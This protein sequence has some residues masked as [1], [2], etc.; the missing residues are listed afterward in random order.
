MDF[1]FFEEMSIIDLQN[2]YI[3]R[4]NAVK[5]IKSELAKNKKIPE[6]SALASVSKAKETELKKDFSLFGGLKMNDELLLTV[7]Q[8]LSKAFIY[9]QLIYILQQIAN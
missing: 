9:G 7:L 1:K 4:L 8:E 3:Q 6:D 5:Y 2:I